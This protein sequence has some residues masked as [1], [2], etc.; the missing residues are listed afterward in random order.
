MYAKTTVL[1]CGRSVLP[2][3]G[4]WLLAA[5]L[6]SWNMGCSLSLPHTLVNLPSRSEC[7]RWD[8]DTVM[9]NESGFGLTTPRKDLKC[10]LSIL[11]ANIKT[12][13]RA[14]LS[15]KICSLLAD[16]EKDQER[17][18]R[19]AAEGARWAQISLHLG[20][21]F[22]GQTH[23]LLAI[24]LGMTV[25]HKTYLAIKNLKRI[26]NELKKARDLAPDTDMGGPQRV[27][28]MIYLKAPGWPTGIGDSDKAIDMLKK[29]C[30]K[31]P[32][33]PL[34]HIFY[35]KALWAVDDDDAIDQIRFHLNRAVSL[36]AKRNWGYAGPIWMKKIHKIKCQCSILQ[37]E[38]C[39]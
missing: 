30:Q 5:L 34:N 16:S 3:S 8:I 9:E 28:A 27:L 6:A 35:A 10:A 12:M 7:S 21:W 15:A 4:L 38:A 13:D 20:N 33:H 14:L 23:Y 29:V 31:Y 17:R 1:G 36:I 2:V 18:E 25:E 37:K 24:N 39:K 26:M 19:F 32:D 11:R 22:D